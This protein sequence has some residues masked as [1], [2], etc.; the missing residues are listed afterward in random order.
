MWY[1]GLCHHLLCIFSQYLISDGICTPVEAIKVS[2]HYAKENI[3]SIVGFVLIES[4]LMT[5]W[6]LLALCTCGIGYLILIPMVM[7]VF[8]QFYIDHKAAIL[9]TAQKHSIPLLMKK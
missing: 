5:I 7:L 9:Q 6:S 3:G 8:C 2:F 4:I 1:R